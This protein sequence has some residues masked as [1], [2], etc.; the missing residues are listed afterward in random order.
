MRIPAD[1]FS[2]R[3]CAANESHF[4]RRVASLRRRGVLLTSRLERMLSQ[5]VNKRETSD[6]QQPALRP[7]LTVLALQILLLGA[8]MSILSSSHL[9]SS[10]SLQTPLLHRLSLYSLSPTYK[11]SNCSLRNL[12]ASFNFRRRPFHVPILLQPAQNILLISFKPLRPNDNS[13][14]ALLYLVPE[15]LFLSAGTPP[16]RKQTYTSI[17]PLHVLLRALTLP[18]FC[19][20]IENHL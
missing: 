11:M 16:S 9:L 8:L 2:S 5:G 15:T 6:L 1:S 4:D 3:L 7:T 10:S 12:H 13:L 18:H 20:R 17:I 19:T 14:K